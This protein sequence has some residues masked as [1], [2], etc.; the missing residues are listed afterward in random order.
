MSDGEYYWCLTH[1]KVEGPH[2][3]KAADRMGP[4]PTPEAAKAWRETVETR[5]EEWEGDERPPED[6][7][8]SDGV[9]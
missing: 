5:N 1:Q 9:G 3:D 4:Y 2:E 7:R 8:P 6:D